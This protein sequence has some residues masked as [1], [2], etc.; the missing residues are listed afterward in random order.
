MR[1]EHFTE[2]AAGVATKRGAM[3]ATMVAIHN[4]GYLDLYL[5]VFG[6]AW[7]K[8]EDRANLLFINNKNQAFTQAAAQCGVA[9]TGFPTQVGFPDY[10]REECLDLFLFNNSPKDFWRGVAGRATGQIRGVTRALP[11]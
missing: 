11:K 5:S 1:F 6:P 7:S 3:A 9:D 8:G 2:R 10:D 4:D